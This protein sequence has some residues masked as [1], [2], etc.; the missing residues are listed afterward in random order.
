MC[1]LFRRTFRFFTVFFLSTLY[2]ELVVQFGDKFAKHLTRTI[3]RTLTVLHTFFCAKSSFQ[4][5]HEL[6]RSPKH[7]RFAVCLNAGSLDPCTDH[8]CHTCADRA[9]HRRV[10]RHIARLSISFQRLIKTIPFCAVEQENALYHFE[11]TSTPVYSSVIDP[12]KIRT[13]NGKLPS[14]F[15]PVTVKVYLQRIFEHM[16][17]HR[18]H[19][20]FTSTHFCFPLQ[21]YQGF[22]GLNISQRSK[23]SFASAM[24]I[25]F[26]VRHSHDT[27]AK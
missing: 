16:C 3:G 24:R 20:F 6:A 2:I 9:S 11:T 14:T 23:T 25:A 13:A 19:L 5:R 22:S 17:G 27:A 4:L 21:L 7:L 18:L 12:I 1:S 15:A 8:A 26:R 10:C